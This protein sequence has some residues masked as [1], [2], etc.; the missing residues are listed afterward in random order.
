M[1]SH[2][3]HFTDQRTDQRHLA[4]GRHDGHTHRH[5]REDDTEETRVRRRPTA[6]DAQR[7]APPTGATVHGYDAHRYD[8]IEHE[9]VG[10][11]LY[12][13][14]DPRAFDG[15]HAPYAAW[16]APEDERAAVDDEAPAWGAS[17][18]P[19]DPERRRR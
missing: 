9:Y 19:L 3:S 14:D 8:A 1:K 18:T 15:E 2:R 16:G 10:W 7:T 5:E 6:L 17:V 4:E 13:S 12:P 11:A